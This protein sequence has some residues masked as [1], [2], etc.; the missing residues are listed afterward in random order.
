[1]TPIKT[2]SLLLNVTTFLALIL[3]VGGTYIYTSIWCAISLVGQLVSIF[4]R[5]KQYET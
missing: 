2:Q 1:M 3:Q 5:E 4:I